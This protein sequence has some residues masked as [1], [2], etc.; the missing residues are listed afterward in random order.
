MTVGVALE[1]VSLAIRRLV[2]RRF[3]AA[4]AE[5]AIIG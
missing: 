3:I 4:A 5:R 2:V 1:G